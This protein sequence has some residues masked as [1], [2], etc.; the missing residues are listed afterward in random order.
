MNFEFSDDSNL[1]RDQAR[2]FLADRCGPK[3]VREVLE[4]KAPYARALWLDIA[5]MGWLGGASIPEE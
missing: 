3:V 2:S 5:G 1:L 4:G